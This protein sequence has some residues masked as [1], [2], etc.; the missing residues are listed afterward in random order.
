MRIIEYFHF[1]K[2]RSQFALYFGIVV[3]ILLS[4]NPGTAKTIFYGV[5]N[6]G[7]FEDVIGIESALSDAIGSD[8]FSSYT[9]SNLSGGDIY[10]STIALQPFLTPDDTLVWYYSGHGNFFPDDS[11]G[12]ETSSGSFALDSYDEALGLQGNSDWL[13]DDQ[14]AGALNNLADTTA[15]ILTIAD[16]C[17]AGGLVGGIGDLNTVSGLTFFGSSSELGLSYAFSSDSYSLFTDSLISGLASWSADSNSDGILWA[18]EWFQYSHSATVGSLE[19]QQPVFYGEDLIIASQM[20]TPVPLPGT[21][22]L[23]GTGILSLLIR[24]RFENEK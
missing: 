7:Y 16:M 24:K 3:A 17:Y 15:G 9:Y 4:P 8:A 23:L 19:L 14:L 1:K 5:G 13:S 12:D 6:D 22:F 18:S 2:M 11:L 20:P 10:D 21:V